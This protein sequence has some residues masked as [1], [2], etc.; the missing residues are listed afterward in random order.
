MSCG[1]VLT[2]GHVETVGKPKQIEFNVPQSKSDGTRVASRPEDIYDVKCKYS[3]YESGKSDWAIYEIKTNAITGQSVFETQR[4]FFRIVAD[5]KS[6]FSSSSPLVRV[7]GFGDDFTPSGPTSTTPTEGHNCYSGTLQTDTGQLFA[8]ETPKNSQGLTQHLAKYYVDTEHSNSGSPVYLVGTHLAL[9]I[10]NKSVPD[11]SPPYNLGTGFRNTLLTEAIKKFSD[12]DKYIDSNYFFTVPNGDGS[13]FKPY[14]RLEYALAD[15]KDIGG[16]L[17][18]VA[19]YYPSPSGTASDP[20]PGISF[21]K[22]PLSKKI[23]IKALAG[24]VHI[25]R[26]INYK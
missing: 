17:G 15:I 24:K 19:G 4:K 22:P 3:E 18:I 23:E 10:H 8:E 7:T 25:G 6:F 20:G 2:A 14:R 16:K 1:C 11:E 13:L 9:A 12:V 21:P 26:I 5:F